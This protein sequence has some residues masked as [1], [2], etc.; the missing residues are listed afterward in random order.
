MQVHALI[1]IVNDAVMG[2][3][4]SE[5]QVTQGG[6]E[7]SKSVDFVMRYVESS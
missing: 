3:G 2:I 4:V 1:E 7:E 6:R 5:T